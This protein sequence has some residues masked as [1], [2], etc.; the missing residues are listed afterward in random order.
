MGSEGISKID[1]VG[2]LASM[3]QRTPAAGRT[4]GEEHQIG[5]SRVAAAA[6][7]ARTAYEPASASPEARVGSERRDI[8]TADDTYVRIRYNK[9]AHT[10]VI[11]VRSATSDEVISEIPPEGW[12]GFSGNMP[13]PRGTIVE[14][15]R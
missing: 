8:R 4:S 7:G 10:Y 5:D 3:A 1:P 9:S 12:A 6:F 15:A 2:L 14:K 11:Q 13:L